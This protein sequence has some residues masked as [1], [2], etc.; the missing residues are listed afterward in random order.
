[1]PSS[2]MRSSMRSGRRWSRSSLSVRKASLD[3]SPGPPS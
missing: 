3:G 1:V 2:R